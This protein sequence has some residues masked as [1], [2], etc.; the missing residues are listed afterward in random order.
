VYERFV[1]GEVLG[2]CNW[3]L[4]CSGPC[5]DRRDVAVVKLVFALG[6]PAGPVVTGLGEQARQAYREGQEDQ[7]GALGLC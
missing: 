3:D 4:Q 7:L 5:E 6:A 2:L 1:G